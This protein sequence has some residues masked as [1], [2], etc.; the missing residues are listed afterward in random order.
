MRLSSHP[1][2]HLYARR[3]LTKKTLYDI[4]LFVPVR[5]SSDPFVNLT[6]L[7]LLPQELQ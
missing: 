2:G 1:F 5:E 3:V 4:H 7:S 6:D